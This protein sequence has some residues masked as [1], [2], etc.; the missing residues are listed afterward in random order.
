MHIGKLILAGLLVSAISATAA[1]AA[2]TQRAAL[3]DTAL[4]GISGGQSVNTATQT[5]TANSTGATITAGQVTSG[6]VDFSDNAFQNFNGIGNVVV[7]TG[8]N[9]VIQGSLQVY[10]VTAPSP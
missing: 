5:L 7:N 9:N 10:M 3:D 6:S 4:A 8:N 1:L 2:D